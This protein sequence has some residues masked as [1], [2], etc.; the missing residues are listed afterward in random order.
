MPANNSRHTLARQWELLKLLPNNTHGKTVNELVDGLNKLD[1]K[2]GH[3]Q[4]ERDL[5]M[6]EE[7][8]ALRCDSD[9]VPY[10]WSLLRKVNYAMSLSEAV[11]WQL[12]AKTIK[13]LL[14][15][16]ILHEVT[17][18]FEQA[19]KKLDSLKQDNNS[20]TWTEKIRVVEPTLPLVAP[21]IDIT[22]LENIQESVLKQIQI[23]V[24]YRAANSSLS[25]ELTLH[26]LALVQR[27]LVTYLVATVNDYV[28]IR[29]F[30]I[31]RIVNIWL[32]QRSAIIPSNFDIDKYIAT[33]AL[34]F[35]NGEQ[36]HLKLRVA[37]WLKNI[38]QETPLTTNQ[39]ISEQDN[40]IIVKAV[41]TLTPQLEW[42]L[43]SQA[44]GLE[45]LEPIELREKLAKRLLLA[46]EQGFVAQIAIS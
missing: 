21:R 19:Q 44:D 42:W 24:I 40:N 31:H 25:K 32:T 18:Y 45:V 15:A 17:P 39:E 12:V 29:I 8:L 10:R 14:P 38:L 5:K 2:I 26:P 43:L 34:H 4:V 37:N 13:N 20:A 11:S 22:I 46:A 6:L 35:G 1:F 23:E 41:I 28:D 27:G 36:I 16:N 7:T 30:A 9:V 33:G 3:R